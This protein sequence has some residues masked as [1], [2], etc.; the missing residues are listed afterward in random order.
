M[1]PPGGGGAPGWTRSGS[2]GLLR[3]LLDL[4]PLP[5]WPSRSSAP[6][7]AV[8]DRLIGGLDLLQLGSPSELSLRAGCSPPL[9]GFVHFRPFTGSHF[10]CPLPGARGLPSVE[11]S[12][13]PD[14]VPPSRFPTA[15]TASSTR[16]S[17]A[18]CIPQ[19][20]MGFAVFPTR[21]AQIRPKASLRDPRLSH[22]ALHTPRRIPLASSR[23]ASPR[24]LPSCRFHSLRAASHRLAPMR[25]PHRVG[26]ARSLSR[27]AWL[28]SSAIRRS[29][30][31][32]DLACPLGP[33]WSRPPPRR[34]SGRRR[35]VVALLRQSGLGSALAWGFVQKSAPARGP[36]P[37]NCSRP[38]ARLPKRACVLATHTVSRQRRRSG[39]KLP[40]PRGCECTGVPRAEA[41]PRPPAPAGANRATEV[42]R[43]LPLSAK[44]LAP[45]W[46]RPPKRLDSGSS[47][48]TRPRAAGC[49]GSEDPGRPCRVLA[50][51]GPGRSPGLPTWR[52]AARCDRSGP[53]RGRP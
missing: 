9:V 36:R 49:L 31:G 48:P 10:G 7:P 44:P 21:P 23:T 51:A 11:Q 43:P 18:C 17:R 8:A 4:C 34:R 50:S 22:G 47:H 12:H 14:P 33:A 3:S 35:S 13:L 26:P 45:P 53:P 2:F 27:R 30:C 52:P 38:V 19:P 46:S 5:G 20:V 41:R 32:V 1:P 37:S 29:G 16:V 42:A 25:P 40:S 15:L 28:G 39:S 24:P 6:I